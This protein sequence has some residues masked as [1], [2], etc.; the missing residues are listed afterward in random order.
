MFLESDCLGQVLYSLSLIW[1]MKI[2]IGYCDKL[3]IRGVFDQ[4]QQYL[5]HS[6]HSMHFIATT[7]IIITITITGL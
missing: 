3:K 5:I 2:I 4:I 1:K 7:T 6:K